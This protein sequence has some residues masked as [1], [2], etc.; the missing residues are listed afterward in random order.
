MQ[1]RGRAASIMHAANG[2]ANAAGGSGG[3]CMG[4][5]THSGGCRYNMV[6]SRWSRLLW[7]GLACIGEIVSVWH[8]GWAFVL[9]KLRLVRR[10]DVL[11][12]KLVNV[13]KWSSCQREASDARK[14]EATM[15]PPGKH[16]LHLRSLQVLARYTRYIQVRAGILGISYIA[17]CIAQVY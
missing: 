3:P 4:A 16:L 2:H 9:S 14:E 13:K 12:T 5:N 7:R 6:D 17:W 11:Q 15:C 1:P 10:K 8:W